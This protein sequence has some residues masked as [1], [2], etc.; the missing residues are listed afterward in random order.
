M[1][2][3]KVTI[4]D[5]SGKIVFEDVLNPNTKIAKIPISLK[6]GVYLLKLVVGNLNLF[7]QKLIVAN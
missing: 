3:D 5:L 7:S 1:D 2:R 4:T 6:S